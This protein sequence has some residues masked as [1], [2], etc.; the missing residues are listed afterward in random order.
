M[1][2]LAACGL[3]L[4][5]FPLPARAAAEVHA[6]LDRTNLSLGESAT[7]EVAVSGAGGATGDPEFA[8]PRGIEIL[9][10]S[11]STNFTVINGR[12]SSATVFS[13][14]LGPTSAGRF[15]IGPVRVRVGGQILQSEVLALQVASGVPSVSGASGG[16]AATLLV[17]VTP[18]NPWVGQPLL[19]RVRLVLREMLAED[20]LYTPPTTTGFWGESTSK[21]ESYNA[22]QG[23][24]RVLVTETRT[25][26]YP[27]GMGRAT[28]SPAT[29]TLALSVP[30]SDDPLRWATGRIPRREVTVRSNPVTVSVRPLP[31]GAPVGFDGAVGSLSVAWSADRAH[32][33]LDV[34]IVVQLD[35]RGVGN[36]PLLHSPVLSSDDAEAFASTVDDSFGPPGGESAGRRRFQWNVLAHHTGPLRIDAPAL[37]WFD[38][39]TAS[40]RR[41]ALASLRID[42]GPATTAGSNDRATFPEAFAVTGIEPGGKPA[43]PWACALGGLL[44]GAAAAR[45]RSRRKGEDPG[46]GE[47]QWMEALQSARRE[48]FWKTADAAAL[49]LTGTGRPIGSLAAEIASA[50]YGG[51]AVDMESLRRRLIEQWSAV[52]P[53]T[54]A[55][56]DPRLLAAALALAGL[57]LLVV[58]GPRWG[59]SRMDLAMRSGDQA[60]RAGELGRARATW[61][62]LWDAGWRDP[63]L[64]ARLAWTE[65]RAG[66]IGRA[67]AWSLRGQ[68]LDPR[69]PALRWVSDRIRESGGLVGE[70][71]TALPLRATEWAAIALVMGAV[72]G[73]AWPSRRPLFIV[74]LALA[75][76]SAFLGPAQQAWNA[77]TARAVVV[78]GATLEGAGVEVG[79]GQVVTVLEQGGGRIRVRAGR[80]IVGWLP[81][82][83]LE[84]V[85]GGS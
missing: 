85:G 53:A 23:G 62:R 56:R 68:A 63:A 28:I 25:R 44:L 36:L 78:T 37:S 39:A 22:M 34:P 84:L 20:P 83:S 8:V 4:L 60:A 15:V 13:Y 80:D 38:P 40:Y 18:A 57:A 43:T 35:V 9:A 50:R 19:M 65:V 33:S 69:D 54:T 61:E 12:G 70:P 73:F 1:R 5:L 74:A 47:R 21:P 79:P 41:A 66:A 51:G 31:P 77:R 26:L 3:L 14:E 6:R 82:G 16:N 58:F 24:S 17:D 30:G 55:R 2:A 67:A 45:W 76:A 59:E 11:S 48:D 10:S 49:A 27:L 72:A 71:R 32:T 64:A 7:L 75:L 42:V 29:A 46:A 52:V 81:A